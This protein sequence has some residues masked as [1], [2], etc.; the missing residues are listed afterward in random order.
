MI[1]LLLYTSLFFI[2]C[3]KLNS[4]VFEKNKITI[5]DVWQIVNDDTILKEQVFLK[6]SGKE[7][8][9]PKDNSPIKDCELITWAFSRKGQT[10]T[11][12]TGLRKT[13]QD[14]FVHPIRILEYSILEFCPFPYIQF[15]L[16]IGHKWEWELE[17]IPSFYYKYF[18]KAPTYNPSIKVLNKY[19]IENKTSYHLNQEK[20]II[21]CYLIKGI[22]YSKLGKTELSFYYSESHG[23]LEMEF[24]T[25]NKEKFLFKK[26]KEYID[27]G[28]IM[29]NNSKR[30]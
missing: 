22:G 6:Q 24:K 28:A 18:K 2:S 8:I 26:N 12:N 13:S 15:P 9:N 5:Y 4:Q 27:W 11:E 20:Q 25:L 19:I 7:W 23:F 1:K 14:M 17:N 30:K 29:M 16:K 10:Y 21:D 3:L